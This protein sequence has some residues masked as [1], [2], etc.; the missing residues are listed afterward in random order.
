MSQY[1][2]NRLWRLWG[3]TT[4][5]KAAPPSLSE[6]S[7]TSPP[8][9]IN[10]G[11]DFG[12]S[13]TKVSFRDVGREESG[14]V[15][16][17]GSTAKSAIIPSVVTVDS[18]GGLSLG[19]PRIGTST[20]AIVRFLKMRLAE[21]SF[22]GRLPVVCEIDLNDKEVV[23]ALSSW[24]L[25]TVVC[26]A[27]AW[28]LQQE[29]DRVK[30]RNLQWSANVCVP[31]E[32]YDSP[33]RDVFRGVL[34]V[35]WAWVEKDEIPARLDCLTTSYRETFQTIE[36]QTTDC[37]AIPE[38]AAAVQSFLT[39][40]EAMPGI[41]VYFDIGG[42]TVDGVAFNY[43][44][45]DGERKTNFYSGKVAP[46]GVAAIASRLD[47]E[48]VEGVEKM[49]VKDR[50]K[51]DLREKL[52]PY[53]NEIQQL[54]GNVIMTGKQKDG[55]NWQHNNIQDTS[56]PR[57]TLARLKVSQMAPLIV[58]VGGGGAGAVWYQR[59]ILST[60]ED[61]NHVNAGIPP[62]ELTEVPK[63]ADLEM[64]GLDDNDFRRFAIAYGLSV[65]YGEG[66]EI[67]L[68]SQFPQAERPKVSQPTGVVDYL[69]SKDVYD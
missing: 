41:Y 64:K 14:I 53:G 16:F 54:V 3:R 24:F 34:A 67:G 7:A 35:A 39:S 63:P 23:C 61:F 8:L 1:R 59:S 5:P 48:D 2:R 4:D 29:A 6:Q 18:A 69:D 44:N 25:A 9:A 65:P 43:V 51:P 55:R 42:G 46:L 33:A 11:I 22:P 37:H 36:R 62:Y 27:Q 10:L 26:R 20:G 12:T 19:P 49:L 15:T 68:P 47:A 56:R 52:A 13:F 58:F 40:R 21:V 45:I 32:H 60:Y 28:V 30:G 50:L 66:P 38:I 57:K 31:V 17:G